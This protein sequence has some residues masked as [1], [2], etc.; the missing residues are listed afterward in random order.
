MHEIEL[1]TE[2]LEISSTKD[3]PQQTTTPILV[4]SDA[5]STAAPPEPEE[6]P[7]DLESLSSIDTT[8]SK[9]DSAAAPKRNLTEELGKAREAVEEGLVD[10]VKVVLA[11]VKRENIMDDAL[12]EELERARLEVEDAQRRMAELRRRRGQE[13]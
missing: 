13:L 3:L 12:E 6:A 10:D 9:Q 5:L 4:S 1:E 7:S 2:E 8:S 11:E